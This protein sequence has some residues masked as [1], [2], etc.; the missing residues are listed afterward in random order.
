MTL[1]EFVQSRQDM[2]P[3]AFGLIV[4]DQMFSDYDPGIVM[5]VYGGGYWIERKPDGTHWLLLERD[6]YTS[7][8]ETLEQLE[9]RLWA[10]ASVFFD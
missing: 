7:P 4:R 1:T 5:Q 10:F 6:E 3:E 8:P 2:T 9:A